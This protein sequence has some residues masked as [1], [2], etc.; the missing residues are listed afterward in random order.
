MRFATRTY[1]LLLL[2][3]VIVLGLASRMLVDDYR[4]RQNVVVARQLAA[5]QGELLR[6]VELFS[7]ERGAYNAALRKDQPTD[8]AGDFLSG[9]ARNL[10]ATFAAALTQG[11]AAS[12]PAVDLPLIR[13]IQAAA[14]DWRRRADMA[15]TLRMAA[16]PA[17]V[18]DGY[19]PAMVGQAAALTPALNAKMAR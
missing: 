18:M 2:I 7:I 14:R 19:V 6:L 15:V 16:R 17:D 4:H 8:P 13:Q 11:E 3:G 5:T 12:H 1:L 9:P 10:D